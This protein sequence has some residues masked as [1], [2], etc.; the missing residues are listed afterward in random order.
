MKHSQQKMR[1]NH[2]KLDFTKNCQV[3]LFSC[4]RLKISECPISLTQLGECSKSNTPATI[5]YNSYFSQIDH[6][7]T[8]YFFTR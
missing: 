6:Q 4:G 7:E 3:S 1:K 5:Q 2:N 8:G